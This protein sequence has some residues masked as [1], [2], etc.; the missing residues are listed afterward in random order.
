MPRKRK[1][2]SKQHSAGGSPAAK[3]SFTLRHATGGWELVPPRC[4]REREADLEEVHSMLELG[5]IDV[6]VDEL[7][8]LLSQCP[9]F[10]E[11]HRLLGEIA[12]AEDDLPLA[13][14]HFGYAYTA[15]NRAIPKRPEGPLPYALPANQSFFQA[16]KGL[17]F[18][19]AQLEKLEMAREVVDRLLSLDPSDPLSVAEL[20]KA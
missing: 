12:L 18:C 15:G 2:K 3:T 9:D 8:W 1:P 11:A 13:R 19:L 20:L 4:V 10:I 17:V 5:E 16:A 14:G 7:R 6:A